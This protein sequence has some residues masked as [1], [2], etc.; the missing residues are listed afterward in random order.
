MAYRL[1]LPPSSSV[2]PVFHISQ[3]KNA[4]STRHTVAPTLPP[5]SALWSVLARILQRRRIAKG[6]SFVHQGLIQ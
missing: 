6:K 1:E 3:L 4:M 2:H 5:S